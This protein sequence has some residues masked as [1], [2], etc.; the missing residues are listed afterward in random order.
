M[1]LL[2]QDPEVPLLKGHLAFRLLWGNDVIVKSTE[3]GR[4]TKARLQQ[5]GQEGEGDYGL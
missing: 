5:T 4:P 2:F 1:S 3:K